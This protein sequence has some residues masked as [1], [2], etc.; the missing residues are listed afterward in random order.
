MNLPFFLRCPALFIF[1]LPCITMAAP[2]VR[3]E[4][5]P[6]GAMQPVA[7]VSPDGATHLVWLSG[8][9]GA[10]D[11]FY[12]KRGPD[13]AEPA[14]PIK[15]NSVAGSAVATGT[16]RGAQLAPGKNGRVH[17]VWFG[18]SKSKEESPNGAPLFYSRSSGKDG[19]I[20][21]EPQ[22]S[23]SGKTAYLDGG[24]SVA[25]NAAGKVWVTWHAA[26]SLKKAAGPMSRRVFIASSGDDGATFAAEQPAID[27]LGACECCGLTATARASDLSILF[28]SAQTPTNRSMTLLSSRDAGRTYTSSIL[29]P[30]ET[31]QCPMSTGALVAPDKGPLWA[32]WETQGKVMLA[33]ITSSTQPVATTGEKAKHPALAVNPRGEVL[34]VWT[35]GTGWQRGGTVAWQVFDAAGKPLGEKGTA[36]HLPV[37]SFAAAISKPDG[38]FVVLY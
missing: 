27:A 7:A 12:Q 33:N 34:L 8:E 2:E 6:A 38:S 35:E 10:S 4:R 1:M 20:A 5:L 37:W 36:P 15:V 11:V 22:R 14:A 31:P 16:V 23:L 28:R 29:S 32:A 30:W 13:I 26:P 9:P 19:G 3:V 25:A 24:P 18:A 17:V 21:F